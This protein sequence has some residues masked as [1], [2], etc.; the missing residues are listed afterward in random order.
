MILPLRMGMDLGTTSVL[1]NVKGKGIVLNEPSVVAYYRNESKVVS[2]G[3]EAETMLG[4]TPPHIQAMRPVRHGVIVNLPVT[5]SMLRY[6][7]RRVG[8]LYRPQVTISVPA[9]VTNVARRA[10]REAALCAGASKVWLVEE[11]IAAGYGAGIDMHAPK[12][13][14]VVDLG[15]GTTDISVIC[16]GVSIVSESVRAAGDQF[17]ATIRDLLRYR[18]NLLI[19]E[20]A[21]EDI[22]ITLGSAIAPETEQ[23][24]E[25]RGSDVVDGTLRPQIISNLHIHQAICEPLQEILDAIKRVLAKTPPALAGDLVTQGIVLTGGGALLGNLDVF[26]S[27][28]LQ[29]PVRVAENPL[30]CVAL[31][32]LEVPLEYLEEAH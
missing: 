5:E 16:N 10:V 28:S 15:G 3:L 4:K 7:F 24:M 18:F 23:Q 11:P 17:N 2:V 12:G 1:I 14:M 9:N 8:L 30:Q 22:K 13:V 29:I 26:L 25:V 32:A 27:R 20:R 6:F 31:G 21:A 19:S